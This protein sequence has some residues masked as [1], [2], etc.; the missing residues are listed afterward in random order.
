MVGDERFTFLVPAIFFFKKSNRP[1]FVA[2]VIPKFIL[3]SEAERNEIEEMNYSSLNL[4]AIS[5]V[6]HPSVLKA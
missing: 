6:L 1:G 5:F 3:D 4:N 2:F